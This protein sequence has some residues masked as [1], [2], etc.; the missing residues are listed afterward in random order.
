MRRFLISFVFVLFVCLAGT[1]E[2]RKLALLVG[3]D[4]YDDVPS[5]TC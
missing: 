1:T 2:A 4:K 5:L 3:V